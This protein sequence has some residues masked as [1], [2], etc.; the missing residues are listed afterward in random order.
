MN[1]DA[2]E[3]VKVSHLD[4][5]TRPEKDEVRFVGVQ[6]KP[7]AAHPSVQLVDPRHHD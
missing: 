2:T 1:V 7:I 3:L 5:L 6:F 4:L